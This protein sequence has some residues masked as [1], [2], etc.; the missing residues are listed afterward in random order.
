MTN[1]RQ[2]LELL[3]ID[4]RQASADRREATKARTQ[5]ECLITDAEDAGSAIH[6]SQAS[7]FA[8]LIPPPVAEKGSVRV[9]ELQADLKRVEA[10]ILEKETELMEAAPTWE[11]RK[12]EES[13]LREQLDDAETTLGTLA[14]KQGRSSQFKTQKD[15]DAH[16]RDTIKSRQSLAASREKRLEDLRKDLATAKQELDTATGRAGEQRHAIVGRKE[17]LKRLKDDLSKFQ[18]DEAERLEKRK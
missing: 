2:R 7:L 16:L 6:S 8:S 14:A 18:A 1:C 9:A 15:R 11:D 10:D 12:K 13:L 17:E 5:V 4:H 3:A